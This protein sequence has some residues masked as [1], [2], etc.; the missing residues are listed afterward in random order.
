MRNF[1]KLVLTS[2]AVAFVAIFVFAF[3]AESFVAVPKGG[4][5]QRA[6]VSA[7][8]NVAPQ[9]NVAAPRTV[10][11]PKST[12]APAP[13]NT[14]QSKSYNKWES[15][16][17]PIQGPGTAKP[18]TGIKPTGVTG[19]YQG[20]GRPPTGAIGSSGV[21]RD[22]S[23]GVLN[24]GGKSVD[25]SIQTKPPIRAN[26]KQIAS[27]QASLD[28]VLGKKAV[29]DPPRT[30]SL[31]VPTLPPTEPT[32]LSMTGST[33]VNQGSIQ[34]GLNNQNEQGTVIGEKGK[35]N[36]H[37]VNHTNIKGAKKTCGPPKPP[38][39]PK[40][41]TCEP[42]KP[43]PT[44]P[45]KQDQKQTQNQQQQQTQKTQ[46]TVGQ[47]TQVKT[48]VESNNINTV[49]GS[50]TNTNNIT[51][52]P[53]ATG[54][55]GGEGGKA[56]VGDTTATGGIGIGG[57]SSSISEGGES[58]SISK[59]GDVTGGAQTVTSSGGSVGNVAGGSV[60]DINITNN[61]PGGVNNSG[62]NAGAGA[63]G[64]VGSGSPTN[65]SAPIVGGGAYPSRWYD[66]PSQP[67]TVAY[68]PEPRESSVTWVENRWPTIAQV[69]EAAVKLPRNECDRLKSIVTHGKQVRIYYQWSNLNPT[70]GYVLYGKLEV[71]KDATPVRVWFA[72]NCTSF[73]NCDQKIAEQDAFLVQVKDSKYIYLPECQIAV[74]GIE[75]G[76]WNTAP[77][78]VKEGKPV[79]FKIRPVEP[80][81]Q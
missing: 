73:Q 18:L 27:A 34:K 32:S 9:N 60:G 38:E 76:A 63:A 17:L 71:P 49:K 41:P 40:P 11:V 56:I 81:R 30:T 33:G 54:G 77:L 22:G 16:Q 47:E 13:I 2:A 6:N 74:T 3:S 51:A 52:N 72:D 57:K 61:I 65:G 21:P 50:V 46:Q 48:D 62:A 24:S 78:T 66:E 59:S 35:I 64:F 25:R 68:Q 69:V 31:P 29:T 1:K 20:G 14:Q 53:T 4:G 80:I 44:K 12:V 70:F 5:A 42:P 58:V 39:P 19:S 8:K 55:K 10:S 26:E 28:K 79:L 23:N 36:Q 15:N 45:P 7:P 67:E 75:E 43:E 37:E